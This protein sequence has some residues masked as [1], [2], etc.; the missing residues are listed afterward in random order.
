MPQMQFQQ[1]LIMKQ[2]LTAQQAT[3][4]AATMKSTT[5]L[6]ASRAAEISEKLNHDGFE[7]KKMRQ[8]RNPDHLLH[9]QSLFSHYPNA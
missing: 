2:I 1:A 6:A 8:D 7:M 3:N 4:R 5:D 9:R